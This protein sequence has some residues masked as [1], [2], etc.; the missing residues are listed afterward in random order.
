MNI[1]WYPGHMTKT[2]RL[3]TEN[4]KLVDIVIE[5]LDARVPLSSTNPDLD[6]LAGNKP[7]IIVMNK[8]DLASDHKNQIWKQWFESKGYGVIL[9]NSITG[10]GIGQIHEQAKDLLREKIE[11]D[12]QRGRVFRPIRAM[13]VG[14]PNVGKSTFINKLVGKSLAKTGDRPGVTR[15]KQWIKI[16]KDFELLDTPGILWPKF[17][18]PMVGLHLAFTGAIK[19]DILD[20][21]EIAMEFVKFFQVSYPKVLVERYKIT[22]AILQGTPYE[23]FLAI[24]K[25]RG[26]LISGG[27]IDTLRTA[28]IIFDEFRGG[29]LGR[30]TLEDPPDEELI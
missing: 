27:E 9:V 6:Q 14:I 13:V 10:Q 8:S 5:L 18:D 23:V 16:R 28:Q 3:I 15:G 2:K 20:I 7:R 1:Q 21:E 24:G 12:R 25:K 29:K 4:L 22:D 30:F 19:D 17:E 11:R 26:F